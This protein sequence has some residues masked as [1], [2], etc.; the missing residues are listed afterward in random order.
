MET[1]NPPDWDFYLDSGES[2]ELQENCSWWC[3]AQGFSLWG[4]SFLLQSVLCPPLSASI[5][6]SFLL[7]NSLLLPDLLLLLSSSL[8][9]YEIGF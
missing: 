2:D 3:L 5:C 8:L 4:V 7:V 6:A 1:V 9:W